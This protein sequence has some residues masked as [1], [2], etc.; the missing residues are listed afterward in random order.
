[1]TI[2]AEAHFGPTTTTM[3]AG[4]IVLSVGDDYQSIVGNAPEG[5][6]FWF[7]SGVHRLTDPIE[8]HN[9]QTFISAEGAV[10]DGSHV[11]TDFT[12]DGN[13]FVVGG[14]TQEGE[15]IATTEGA[16]GAVRAGY[17]ESVFVDGTPLTPVDNLTDLKSGHF[18][19]D[20]DN[21]RIYLADN[22]A[23][24]TVEAGVSSGAFVSGAT[25]VTI[26]NLTI[27]QF[28]APIQHAAIQGGEG[29]TVQ[30]NEVHLNYGVGIAVGGNSKIVG[31]DVHDNGEMGIDGGGDNVLV[32]GNEIHSNGFWSG[33][34]V[35]WEGGGSKFTETNNLVVRDN[36]SHD[37]HGFGLWTDIDNIN[38]L[39]E[40]NLVVD[41]DG[42]GINHEISYD[43]I[44]RDNTVM[45]N[46]T[47]VQG[48]GWLWGSQ[49][50]LQNSQNVD[51]YDNRVDMSGGLNGIGL[52]QQDRGTGT[53]GEWTTTNNTIHD[54]VLVSDSSTGASGGNADYNEQ[55]LLDG[56]NV[57][58]NNEY[59]MPDGDHWWWSGADATSGANSDDWAGYVGQSGQGEG[60]VL[61]STPIDT[62]S[63]L[64]DGSGGEQT[65]ET[66]A[67]PATPG[68][69]DGSAA[70][71]VNGSD[72]GATTTAPQPD[73]VQDG[74][75]ASQPQDTDAAPATPGSDDGSTASPGDP[76]DPA[77]D[78][79]ADQS[80]SGASSGWASWWDHVAA[81]AEPQIVNDASSTSSDGG[82]DWSFHGSDHH[83]DFGSWHGW[84]G[85]DHSMLG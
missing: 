42:G 68:S 30:N 32:Q 70:S 40:G 23:G 85:S 54:N 73:P 35:Y 49:I 27:E 9:G 17:P 76:A 65:Q 80:D 52:I 46:G 74:S 58:S 1:M 29:W 75:S 64:T 83:A 11:L 60:S 4:A 66:G 28:D 8:P 78:A 47:D 69:E 81:A 34:D 62:S 20:Y 67:A 16:E 50:Q 19:F 22:P 33:I 15:R 2:S 31:N 39:Y 59:H 25:D 24:H 82:F 38:T 79:G 41:N 6:T 12:Q 18:Y 13:Y 63:W 51:V 26:S 5:A 84:H 53:Y 7:E 10:L 56:G 55:G 36:Y 72:T 48:T 3:P 14:Q 21:D 57:F 77:A 37:N 45:G 44:I 61:T 71:P 43:A